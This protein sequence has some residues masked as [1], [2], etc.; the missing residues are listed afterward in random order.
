M[1]SSATRGAG[2][3][4]ADAWLVAALNRLGLEPEAFGGYFVSVLEEEDDDDDDVGQAAVVAELLDDMVPDASKHEKQDFAVELCRRYRH[5]LLQ[6]QQAQEEQGKQKQEQEERHGAMA[7]PNGPV[8]C[9]VQQLQQSVATLVG[10]GQQMAPANGGTLADHRCCSKRS[11]TKA[12][13]SGTHAPVT[14]FAHWF[15]ERGN[16]TGGND[17]SPSQFHNNA[18]SDDD[19]DG[20]TVSWEDTDEATYQGDH[21]VVLAGPAGAKPSSHRTSRTAPKASFAQHATGTARQQHRQRSARP[22]TTAVVADRMV[23]HALGSQRRQVSR[24]APH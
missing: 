15:A 7:S 23:R 18:H 14:L 6:Q 20:S 12:R 3:G 9:S 2:S 13:P 21:D 16:D 17:D 8:C 10:Q 1:A 22:Q 19:H 5:G 24:G 4:E 11:V